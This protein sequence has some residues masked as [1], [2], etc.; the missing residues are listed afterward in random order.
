[1][2]TE[3][4]QQSIPIPVDVVGVKSITRQ[5]RRQEDRRKRKNR[6]K[7]KTAVALTGWVGQEEFG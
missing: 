4:H 3:Q 2:L 6:L 5:L 7:L 1:M